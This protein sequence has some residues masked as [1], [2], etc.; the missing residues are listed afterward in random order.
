MRFLC[1]SNRL[2]KIAQANP[3][4]ITLIDDNAL[5]KDSLKKAMQILLDC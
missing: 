3:T 5:D 4:Q 1:D 2:A